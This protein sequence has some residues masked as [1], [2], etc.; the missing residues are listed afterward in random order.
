M[1]TEASIK[2][3]LTESPSG[4]I[5]YILLYLTDYVVRT[6]QAQIYPVNNWRRK[7]EINY[8]R[9]SSLDYHALHHSIVEIKQ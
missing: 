2:G 3:M 6:S 8:W 9:D 7:R 4:H 1:R 5:M